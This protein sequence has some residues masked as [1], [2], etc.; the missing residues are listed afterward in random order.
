[1]SW[2]EFSGDKDFAD[3][4]TYTTDSGEKFHVSRD[5]VTGF[6]RVH[7][8]VGMVPKVMQGQFTDV[9]VAQG[10]VEAHVRAE[11]LHREKGICPPLTAEERAIKPV[12]KKDKDTTIF[13]A[14]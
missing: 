3:K 1:M 8:D 9:L 7:R 11:K 13:A 14:G 2:S 12:A 6:W 10:K 4:R 5:P